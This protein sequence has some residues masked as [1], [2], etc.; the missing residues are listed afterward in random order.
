MLFICIKGLL[1]YTETKR[2][3]NIDLSEQI[4]FVGKLAGKYILKLVG[5]LALGVLINGVLLIVQWDSVLSVF[6]GK[7]NSIFSYVILLAIIG[8]PLLYFI[9]GQKQAVQ[10]ALAYLVNQRKQDIIIWLLAKLNDQHP[11]VFDET[12]I[13]D[14]NAILIINNVSGYVDKVPRSTTRLL[15]KFVSVIGLAEKL[16]SIVKTA[17]FSS[18]PDEEKIN[19]TGQALAEMIPEDL[20]HP[21]LL[22]PMVL[23]AINI[24]LFFL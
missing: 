22:L 13:T 17:K 7:A 19:Q 16:I 10:S 18:L 23:L 24:A 11:D 3:T 2:K 14:D 4:G 5:Y 1:L 6:Q 8:L 9:L 15:A 12:K 21:S 20:I